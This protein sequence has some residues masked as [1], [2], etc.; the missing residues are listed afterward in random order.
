MCLRLLLVKLY[1]CTKACL[2]QHV[3]VTVTISRPCHQ[4]YTGAGDGCVVN[5]YQFTLFARCR[6]M[7]FMAV[8]Q[9]HFLFVFGFV[10][11]FTRR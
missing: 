7:L 4:L 6:D 10:M 5:V 11:F 2:P 8:Q 1:S 9:F 3:A